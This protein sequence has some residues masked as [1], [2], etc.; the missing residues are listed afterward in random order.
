MN[1][2]SLLIRNPQHWF[3]PL[4]L[5]LLAASCAPVQ[6]QAPVSNTP[7]PSL[8]PTVTAT[9]DWFPV[10][11]TPTLKP[12]ATHTPQPDIHPGIGDLLLQDNFDDPSLWVIGS[13]PA[14]NI[15]LANQYLSLAVALPKG[16]LLTARVN[17]DL[18]D[19]YA[20][21]T[22]QPTLCSMDDQF[23]VLFR[24]TELTQY[25]RFVV[26]CDGD[27]RLER[28]RVGE[29]IVIQDWTTTGLFPPGGL[30]PIRLGVWVVGRQMRFSIN[31]NYVF[32]ASDPLFAKGSIGVF[33]R[34]IGENPLT[35][36]FTDL[37]VYVASAPVTQTATFTPIP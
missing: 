27:A 14:G 18:A 31:D 22:A 12:T 20:E 16:Y 17:T 35:V 19:Y 21:I 8:I 3:L 9:I 5:I 23:G 7:L 36:A 4:I 10:T 26:T 29:A 2:S 30:L 1:S 32:A 11:N 15:A 6:T 37:K 33:A 34:S 24:A 28:V 13:F 25:Y